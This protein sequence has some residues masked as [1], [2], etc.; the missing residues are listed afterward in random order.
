MDNF[1]IID[2]PY[3]FKNNLLNDITRINIDLNKFKES[4]LESLTQYVVIFLRLLTNYGACVILL[5][6]EW[7]ISHIIS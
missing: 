6:I 5:K 3:L 1:I 2:Y 4:I 7:E